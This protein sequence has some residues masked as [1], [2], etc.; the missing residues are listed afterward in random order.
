MAFHAIFF[1][2]WVLVH[3]GSTLIS[4]TLVTEL[5][6]IF[7]FDTAMTQCAVGIVAIRTFDL[8]FDDRVMGQH[9]GFFA[10]VL[11]TFKT[12]FRLFCLRLGRFV[13]SMA[14]YTRHIF[15][16]M[17]RVIPEHQIL[18]FAVATLA[19]GILLFH[20]TLTKGYDVLLAAACK[21]GVNAS[22]TDFTIFAGF[23]MQ[24]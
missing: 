19:L 16:L 23:A 2:R 17:L 15:R 3:K 13:N 14:G 7:S 12:F 10:N 21:V 9:V 1:D 18:V 20:V 4:V 22:V 24:G 5:V 6:G 8:A 11:V